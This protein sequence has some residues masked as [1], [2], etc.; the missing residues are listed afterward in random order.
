MV[1][2]ISILSITMGRL[3]QKRT[4]DFSI[5]IATYDRWELL[6]GLLS[7]IREHFDTA[8]VEYEVIVA[9]NSRNDEI[10]KKIEQ[11]VEVFRSS[12]R[13]EF[14]T[15][16]EPLAGKCRAQNAAIKLARGEIIAF[17]D[18]DVVVTPE[19]LNVAANFFKHEAFDVMQGPILVPPEVEHDEN[20]VRAQRKF[21][22]INFVKYPSGLKEIKTLTGANMAVRRQLFSKI[23]VFNEE[24]GP[25]RSG[26]S[27]DVEFA[28]RVL[29]A[30][31]RIGYEHRA[32][33]YHIVDWSRLTEEFF[34]DRHEQQGRSRLI[35]K[36]QSLASIVPN[37]MRSV[38][39]LAWYSMIGD[40]RNKYRAKG[41]YF[42][43]R[44]MLTEKTKTSSRVQV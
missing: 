6:R 43:Y 33:V 41:R 40:V 29:K 16:E 3:K 23:G 20:F 8:G 14:R 5:V 13:A 26:I 28:K 11:V 9:D 32:A 36:K 1:A 17:F 7:S 18:D 19:W 34:R 44:A 30:G 37:L 35:Y 21:R 24:L 15:V 27:E 31:G 22:T 38:W 2:K 25:G 39:T 42:H 12:G 10:S 4:M